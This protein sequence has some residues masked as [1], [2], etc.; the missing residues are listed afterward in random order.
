MKNL[1]LLIA[2]TTMVLAD[3]RD[4]SCNHCHD[5]PNQDPFEVTDPKCLIDPFIMLVKEMLFADR[6]QSEEHPHLTRN[7]VKDK[8]ADQRDRR[9]HIEQGTCEF[10][11][12]FIPVFPK[13]TQ[14]TEDM[15]RVTSN[16]TS[17]SRKHGDHPSFVIPVGSDHF[18]PV[19]SK[20]GPEHEMRKRMWDRKKDFDREFAN[21]N[22]MPEGDEES[23]WRS[24]KSGEWRQKCEEHLRSEMKSKAGSQMSN[25]MKRRG[26]M[27]EEEMKKKLEDMG[28]EIPD[29]LSEYDC[30]TTDFD[31]EELENEEAFDGLMG[32]RPLRM[33]FIPTMKV[34]IIGTDQSHPFTHIIKVNQL[35]QLPKDSTE[36][37]SPDSKKAAHDCLM[38]EMGSIEIMESITAVPIED[39]FPIKLGVQMSADG[40]GKLPLVPVKDNYEG[41]EELIFPIKSVGKTV[42]FVYPKRRSERASRKSLPMVGFA[43]IF[44]VPKGIEICD[45]Q[46]AQKQQETPVTVSRCCKPSEKSFCDETGSDTTQ[47]SDGKLTIKMSLL[48]VVRRVRELTIKL[49]EIA[50][51]TGDVDSVIVRYACPEYACPEGLCPDTVDGR[52][53][54]GCID[55]SEAVRVSGG[56]L[57]V[58]K[59]IIV[60]TVYGGGSTEGM[61]HIQKEVAAAQSGSSSQLSDFA[62][63]SMVAEHDDHEHHDHDITVWGIIVALSLAV[64]AISVAGLSLWCCCFRKPSHTTTTKII[65]IAPGTLAEEELRAIEKNAALNT[66][67]EGIV[68]LSQPG[69]PLP[70]Y[71][72]KPEC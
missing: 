46:D 29:D 35:P 9:H 26:N 30:E 33:F 57:E 20:S 49:F 71:P 43:P 47:R 37:K 65:E 44:A 19:F 8:T 64:I 60:F 23:E 41:K 1:V 21:R 67:A 52:I 6:M 54:M 51:R 14:T 53:A 5:C 7:N 40:R 22:P 10:Q 38:N 69:S 62:V 70:A 11:E 24:K 16:T 18:I 63:D 2:A 3:H 4:S 39:G 61:A 17:S 45:P 36:A 68:V 42:M 27:T 66:P 56:S 55:L 72:E 58:S 15:P 59:S 25:D 12:Q 31:G 48:M 13:T 50:S 34:S 28:I 32:R